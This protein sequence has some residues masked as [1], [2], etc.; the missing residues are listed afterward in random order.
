MK[1]MFVN[2]FA[3][4]FETYEKYA[5]ARGRFRTFEKW[6]PHPRNSNQFGSKFATD[7]DSFVHVCNFY[8]DS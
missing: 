8:N 1:T 2:T 6:G 4:K 5:I 7:Y 3:F